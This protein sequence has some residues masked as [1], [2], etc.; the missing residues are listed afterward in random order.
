MVVSF[1]CGLANAQICCC[2]SFASPVVMS[3]SNLFFEWLRDP[4]IAVDT[5]KT[6]IEAL[7][8]T[9]ALELKGSQD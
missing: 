4:L 5:I 1:N 8:A 6:L 7:L 2:D 9:V 3:E